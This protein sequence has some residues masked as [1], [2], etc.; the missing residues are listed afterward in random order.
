MRV[1]KLTAAQPAV[2]RLEVRQHAD[3]ITQLTIGGPTSV[4]FS[5]EFFVQHIFGLSALFETNRNENR[6]LSLDR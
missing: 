6:L 5:P 1:N 4:S 2:S 3:R